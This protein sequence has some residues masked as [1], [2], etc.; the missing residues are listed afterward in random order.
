MS[1]WLGLGGYLSN[2]IT[3][4]GKRRYVDPQ[5]AHPLGAFECVV[6]LPIRAT[7]ACGGLNGGMN[8]T[9][10]HDCAWPHQLTDVQMQY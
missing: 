2:S 9:L 6:A 3:P 7:F 8:M 10:E 5:N 4:T 1:I